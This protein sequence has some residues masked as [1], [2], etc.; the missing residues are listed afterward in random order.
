[1]LPKLLLK[2]NISE[3]QV[4]KGEKFKASKEFNDDER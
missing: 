3:K 2:K 1:M 4:K